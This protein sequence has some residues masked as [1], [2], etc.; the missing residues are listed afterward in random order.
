MG[1]TRW[2]AVWKV[3]LPSAIPGIMTGSIL[4]MSRAIGEAAPILVI[5]GIVYITWTPRHLMDDFTVMPLQ[6][7]N[8]ASRPQEE[9]HRV[10]AAGI[11]VLLTVLLSFNALAVFIRHKLQKPMS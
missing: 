3:S 9:F 10:A 2:Q 7:Y 1:A 6:I 11:L 5:C 4:A 8:W